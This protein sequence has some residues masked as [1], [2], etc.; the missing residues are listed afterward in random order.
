[1]DSYHSLPIIGAVLVL[2]AGTWM[3]Y[4]QGVFT[5]V[6]HRKIWNIILA[7]SAAGA[8][9]GGLVLAVMLDQRFM[10]DWYRTLLWIH[11]ENGIVMAVISVFHAFWHVKYYA[12]VFRGKRRSPNDCDSKN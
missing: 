6:A 9:L 2:Y 8:C 1:M 5:L 4:R 11:V 7:L 12:C 3:L 10:L